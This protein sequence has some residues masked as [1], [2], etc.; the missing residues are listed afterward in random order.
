MF[1]TR[2]QTRDA[3]DTQVAQRSNRTLVKSAPT[4]GIGE[5]GAAY[6]GGAEIGPGEVLIAK[7]LAAQVP[8]TEVSGR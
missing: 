6:V 5:I 3:R 7:R 8:T 1:D 2:D 4:A